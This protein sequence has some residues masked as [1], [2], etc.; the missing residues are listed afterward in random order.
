MKINT[1]V[2]ILE[3]RDGK[4]PQSLGHQLDYE[5]WAAEHP[6]DV[7]AELEPKHG[8]ALL[9]AILFTSTVWA[10]ALYGLWCFVSMF[11]EAR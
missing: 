6:T 5:Q 10:F 11:W 7:Q 1:T 9:G 2:R 8:W 4:L 3:G